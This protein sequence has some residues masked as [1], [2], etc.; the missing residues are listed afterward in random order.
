MDNELW[1]LSLFFDILDFTLQR[2][3]TTKVMLLSIV[4]V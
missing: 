2:Y 4:E 3:G 1:G